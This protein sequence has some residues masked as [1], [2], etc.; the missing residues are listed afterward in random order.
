MRAREVDGRGWVLE[1]EEG[2][3]GQAVD[4]RGGRVRCVRCEVCD[5]GGVIEESGRDDEGA[6]CVVGAGGEDGC[7]VWCP[8]DRLVNALDMDMDRCDFRS[9]IERF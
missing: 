3:G 5:G 6:D 7:S 1:V 8:G 9:T 4:G 2:I